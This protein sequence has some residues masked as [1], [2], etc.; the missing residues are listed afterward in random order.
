[1]ELLASV[2]WVTQHTV[3]DYFPFSLVKKKTLKRKKFC[4]GFVSKLLFIRMEHVSLSGFPVT[5]GNAL[6]CLDD[7][8]KK[9]IVG[10]ELGVV[11]GFIGTTINTLG[12][13][14]TFH[15]QIQLLVPYLEIGCIILWTDT[16]RTTSE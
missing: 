15:V 13:T 5:Q 16:E 6:I 2:E 8:R 12:T 9:E 11:S 1:M 7:C 14:G 3:K 4:S 10:G